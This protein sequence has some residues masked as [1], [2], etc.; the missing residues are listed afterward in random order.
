[1]S[2]FSGAIATC[3]EVGVTAI[4]VIRAQFLEV[5]LQGLAR[6]AIILAVPREPVRRLELEVLED[7]VL[8]ESLVA[9]HIDLADL[10]ALAFLDIDVD[11]HTVVRQFI[12]P[13]IDPHGVLASAEVLVG[14][15]LLDL[16][17]HGAIE[18]LA[19]RE[20]DIA[21]ALAE[22]F[23]LDVFVALDLEAVDGRTLEHSDHQRTAIPAQFDIAEEAGVVQGADR[24][25]GALRGQAVADV[26][27]EIVV[28][29]ALG[30]TLQTLDTDVLD[31]ERIGAGR[32]LR[33]DRRRQGQDPERSDH[34]E[35]TGTEHRPDA[36][37]GHPN[38]LARSL[39]NATPIKR[40]SSA[41]PRLCPAAWMRS[42]RGEPLIHSMVW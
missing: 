24:F 2:S 27:G 34:R 19:V 11:A 30:D 18:V 42:D 26:D 36:A 23:G 37:E 3:V 38:C 41:M 10:R 31:P 13:G 22:I 16:I 25:A 39:N 28:N 33:R 8:G 4:H 40:N 1:M 35:Q 20:T 29:R 9:D 32:G 17:Q 14:E 6:I 12:D 21:Q 5:S 7:L 15:V